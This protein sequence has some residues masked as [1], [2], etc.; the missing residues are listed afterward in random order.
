MDNF[1]FKTSGN[2]I[3]V[4]NFAPLNN[5]NIIPMKQFITAI[6]LIGLVA[7]A[8]EPKEKEPTAEEKAAME[9]VEQE[10]Q[11]IEKE[12]DAILQ[13]DKD[14]EKELNAILNEN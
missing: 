12:T 5:P 2:Q 1:G 8:G 14:I 4:C 11:S 10:L 6:C 9:Q 3:G 7:C 13:E